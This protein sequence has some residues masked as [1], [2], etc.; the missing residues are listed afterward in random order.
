MAITKASLLS[1]G[2]SGKVAKTVVASKW[3]GKKVMRSYA[4]PANPQTPGQQSQRSVFGDAVFSYRT[5]L[6]DEVIRA[7]WNVQAKTLKKVMSGYNSA[8]GA[9]KDVLGANPSASFASGFAPGGGLHADSILHMPMNDN[10]PSRTI[11][12]I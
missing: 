4:K 8:V 12:D 3:K 2:A 1:L 5:F 10:A 6:T 9:M 7:A 11:T